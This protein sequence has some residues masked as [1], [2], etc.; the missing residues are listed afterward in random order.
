MRGRLTTFVQI[1]GPLALLAIAPAIWFGGP[2]GGIALALVPLILLMRRALRLP[3]APR[4]S[5]KLLV[6][7]ALWTGVTALAVSDWQ[8]AAPKLFGVLLGLSLAYLISAD[9]YSGQWVH[10]LWLGLAIGVAGL[11]A[12]AALFLAEWPQRKLL[13]L[14]NLYTVLPTGPR[15]VDH[16]GRTGGIGPNQIGGALALLAPLTLAL[17]LNRTETR[18]IVCTVAA[19]V[20]V[21][22]L[23]VLVLT[24]SRS[25]YVGTMVGLALVGWWWLRQRTWFR[26]RPWAR[27]AM[28]ATVSLIVAGLLAA[29]AFTWLA[30]LDSTADTLKGRLT[31]WSV[32]T[33]LIGE[34]LYT[35]VGPGQF[36]LVLKSTFPQL[37]ASVAPHIPHAHNL[38]LQSLLDLGLAAAVLLGTL[39]A[40]ALRALITA[41]RA[42]GD[43]SRQLLAVGLVGSL[44]AFFAYGLTDTIAPGARGGLPFWLVLGLALACGRLARQHRRP[45]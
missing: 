26:R 1:G 34:H 44:A 38:V 32:S 18:R 17:S 4:A 19:L 23:A 9:T 35:G 14:D 7:C 3:F 29:M 36:S 5:D 41:A 15:V 22:A 21:F 8:V 30:P 37:S 6:A 42:A 10:L 28:H 16:G 11:I 13:P 20:L 24:Q 2:P 45:A 12:I 27:M 25:A 43:G 31:I 40:V 39:I 33:L